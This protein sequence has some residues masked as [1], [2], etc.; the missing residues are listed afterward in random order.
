MYAARS[1]RDTYGELHF[2][3]DIVVDFDLKVV[4]KKF[5]RRTPAPLAVCR[6]YIPLP[7][8]KQ[9]KVRLLKVNWI[10]GKWPGK[11]DDSPHFISVGR[12]TA[13]II[14]SQSQENMRRIKIA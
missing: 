10:S 8:V 9:K 7:C 4:V 11:S 5:P 3:V 2:V 14:A 1:A 12:Q 6:A 13:T